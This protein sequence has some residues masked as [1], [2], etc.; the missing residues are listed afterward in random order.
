MLQEVLQRAQLQAIPLWKAAGEVLDAQS[1]LPS[2]LSAALDYE[3]ARRHNADQFD[4]PLGDAARIDLLRDLLQPPPP[5]PAPP[6]LLQHARAQFAMSEGRPALSD[7]EALAL[8]KQS[9]SGVDLMDPCLGVRALELSQDLT[10]AVEEEADLKSCDGGGVK[11][12]PPSLQPADGDPLYQGPPPMPQPPPFMVEALPLAVLEAST[13]TFG[14]ASAMLIPESDKRHIVERLSLLKKHLDHVLDSNN[15]ETIVEALEV[16]GDPAVTPLPPGVHLAAEALFVRSSGR[17][18]DGND[19]EALTMLRR[20]LSEAGI[21][22]AP[23]RQR[24]RSMWAERV[25]LLPPPPA[26]CIQLGKVP[27]AVVELAS[28]LRGPVQEGKMTMMDPDV[29]SQRELM[30]LQQRIDEI[31]AVKVPSLIL[32]MA[33]AEFEKEKGRGICSDMEAMDLIIAKISDASITEV[34]AGMEGGR[35]ARVHPPKLVGP[36]ADSNANARPPPPQVDLP[37]V[38]SVVLRAAAALGNDV[39]QIDPQIQLR[40]L[41]TRLEQYKLHALPHSMMTGVQQDF[42]DVC[43]VRTEPLTLKP[44]S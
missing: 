15:Q 43:H 41:R 3:H 35:G 7:R 5:V 11:L 10:S 25:A 23:D 14:H 40:I 33:R 38:P 31:L 30:N 13:A 29:R 34:A 39:T 28:A 37:L 20:T 32:S 21:F 42:Q 27:P 44:G 1:I 4:T 8:M 16:D 24:Q 22:T 18:S 6:A 9:L 2:K 12:R 19:R 26:S 17:P 36:C